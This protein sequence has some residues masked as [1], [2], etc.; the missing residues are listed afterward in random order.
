M[1]V[2]K[3]ENADL[4][5]T[6]EVV[7]E[8][9]DYAPK[10]QSELKKIQSKA[11]LKGFRKGK[12]PMSVVKG[13]YGKSI[14]ADVINQSFNDALFDYMRKEELD[15]VFQPLPS[16]HKTVDNEGSLVDSRSYTM[17]FDL[18]IVP[19]YEIK[20]VSSSDSYTYY[21]VSIEESLIDE[22]L[23]AMAKKNGVNQEV[24]EPIEEN[25]LI[26]LSAI[27]WLDGA[28]KKDGW[29][30]T[31]E[32]LASKISSEDLKSKIIGSSKGEK[33]VANIQDIESGSEKFIRQYLLK[34]EEDDNR[35]IG[36]EFEFTVEVISRLMPVTIDDEFV[37]NNFQGDQLESVEDLRQKVRQ[38]IQSFFD[39]QS[40][41]LLF[42]KIMDFVMDNT[43]VKVSEAFMKRWLKEAENQSDEQIEKSGAGFLN[44]VKWS[45]IKTKLFDAYKISVTEADVDNRIF[46]N[47][48]DAIRQ[49]GIQDMNMIRQILDQSKNDKNERYRAGEELKA[50]KLMAELEQVVQ[51]N[52]EVVTPE[53]FRDL[54]QKANQQNISEN[55]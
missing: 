36:N 45:I 31:F 24:N 20:G 49:Y 22:E 42:R 50:E 37:K 32:V 3:T 6:L 30:T 7:L 16:V 10:Y 25:D 5:T 39:K 38:D 47:V 54:V 11:A 40:S 29:Q 33:F 9:S 17:A 46:A 21:K 43:T 44:E 26:T 15:Y 34:V 19:P 35:E 12:T 18:H 23:E 48:F 8:P 1:I 52:V 27:E 14:L 41:N 4:T 28:P 55:E 2:N 53:Q 51:K 13:M